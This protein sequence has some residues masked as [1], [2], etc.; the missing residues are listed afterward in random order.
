MSCNAQIEASAAGRSLIQGSSTV[1][2]IERECVCVGGTWVAVPVSLAFSLSE[3]EY[4]ME[5]SGQL[6][7]LAVLPPKKGP[8]LPIE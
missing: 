1:R 6:H 5:M 3:S 4:Q 8:P 7:A 2:E